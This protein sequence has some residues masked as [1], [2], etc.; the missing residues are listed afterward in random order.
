MS[1]DL[2]KEFGAPGNPTGKPEATADPALEDDDFG[3]FQDSGTG[4]RTNVIPA[5]SF[6]YPEDLTSVS[7]TVTSGDPEWFESKNQSRSSDLLEQSNIPRDEDDWGEFAGN[8]VLFDADQAIAKEDSHSKQEHV[9]FK[10]AAVEKPTKV[11]LFPIDRR[12]PIVRPAIPAPERVSDQ[13]DYGKF[14][15]W[16]PVDITQYPVIPAKAAPLTTS[17]ADL[18]RKQ[19]VE[20]KRTVSGPPPSNVPPP[21]MLLPLIPRHFKSLSTTVKNSIS[22]QRESSD[23]SEGL[24]QPQMD[25]IQAALATIRAGAHILAGR[26][27][28]WRRDN[29]LSKSMK[30]GLASGKVNGMKLT[31]VDKN[32]SRREDQEAAEVLTTWRKQVGP[33]RSTMLLVKSKRPGASLTL[34]D[35]SESMPVR[36]VKPNEGAVTAPKAC[37]LCGIKRDERVAKIDI[38]VEDSFGEWWCEHWGHVDCVSFWENNKSSLPS[39]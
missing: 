5:D 4:G 1:A 22:T 24:D 34:P 39:R 16:E 19:M 7:E 21:S 15:D 25:Q 27:L 17:T 9:S 31:G 29:I 37:F 6:Q 23:S 28:R 18:G 8:S 10:Q 33:L 20:G 36:V 14:D 32:E 30:I 11:S 12:N 35:I 26:K 2:F 13:D 3:E 38:N